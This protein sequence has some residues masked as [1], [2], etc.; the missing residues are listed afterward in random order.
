[1]LVKRLYMM[2]Q[3]WVNH[4]AFLAI[5]YFSFI[6]LS[7]SFSCLSRCTGEMQIGWCKEW[8]NRWDFACMFKCEIWGWNSI[9]TFEVQTMV[10]T[11]IHQFTKH[12][13]NNQIICTKAHMSTSLTIFFLHTVTA[14]F[15][16]VFINWLADIR[17][18]FNDS[19]I[20]HLLVKLI[21]KQRLF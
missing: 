8:F 10:Q 11:I 14:L 5:S 19:S 15:R 3:I 2:H 12:E 20:K 1:M 16:S 9:K 17:R 18:S 7:F 6:R 21:T 13:Y 4:V